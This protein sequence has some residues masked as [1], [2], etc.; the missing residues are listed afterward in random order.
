MSLSDRKTSAHEA[1]ATGATAD[2][3]EEQEGG[4]ADTLDTG[5]LGECI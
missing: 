1:P 5:G 2:T 4:D 3:G